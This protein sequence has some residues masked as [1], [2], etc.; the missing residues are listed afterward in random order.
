M[1]H[2]DRLGLRPGRRVV[3]VGCGLGD[4]VLELAATVA[5]GGEAVG[6]DSSP[7]LLERARRRLEPATNGV[8]FV[9]GDA[10]RLP[11]D[12]GTFDGALIQRTLQHVADPR[13]AL[14]ELARVTR[15]G[16]VVF[17]CEPDW[18]TLAIAGQPHAVVRRVITTAQ[19]RI[20]NAWIG[21]D[22]PALFA[23]AGLDE[24]DVSAE[25]IVIRDYAAIRALIDLPALAAELEGD[26][27]V[28]ELLSRWE[29]NATAG[30]AFHALTLV[31]VHGLVT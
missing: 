28:G 10:H 13:R 9:L 24:I 19:E 12:A 5:P 29:S 30:R 18:G 22:L 23:D 26:D 4:L 11:F 8:R 27:A 1:H 31:N 14:A 25:T 15:E 7:A 17:A 6:V 20:R 16:G 3:E 21:R 2:A